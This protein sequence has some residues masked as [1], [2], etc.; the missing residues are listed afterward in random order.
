[1]AVPINTVQTVGNFSASFVHPLIAGGAAI[2]LQ[3]FKL[4]ET[5]LTTAQQVMNSK[6]I[7]TVGGGSSTLTNQVKVGKL[8]I[9][10]MRVSDNILDGDVPLICQALQNVADSTGGALRL[11]WQ[12]NGQVTA[13]TFQIF[14]ESCPPI[15]MA[16]NDLPDYPAVFNYSTFS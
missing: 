14:L 8:T 3:G 16:G 4:E 13:I 6:I 11:S 7:P 15:I 10:C 1:M 12:I 5:F 9:N 2:T